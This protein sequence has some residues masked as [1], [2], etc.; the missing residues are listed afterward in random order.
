MLILILLSFLASDSGTFY[1]GPQHDREEKAKQ[2]CLDKVVP[3][4]V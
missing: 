3:Y 2:G 4:L 1:K